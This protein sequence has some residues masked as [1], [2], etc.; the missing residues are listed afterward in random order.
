MESIEIMRMRSPYRGDFV[1]RGFRF[2]G[3][4]RCACIVGGMRGD[5]VQQLFVAGQIVKNLRRME[6]QGRLSAEKG[7]MVIPTV[8]PFSLNVRKRFWAMDNTDVNR[9]FPG[10]SEGETTQRIAAALFE[11]V[12]GYE[13]GVQLAS[14]YMSGSFAPH[15]RV[16]RT[17][18]EDVEGARAFALPYVYLYDPKP[19]D[20]TTLNYNWQVFETKAYSLYSGSTEV[21]DH[22][23]GK[24]TWQA[25]LRFLR[26]VGVCEYHAHP[27]ASPLVF[28]G[29]RL[30][31]VASER[32]GM[33]YRRVAVGESVR[34]GDVLAR[35]LDPFTGETLQTLT[36]P[37]DGAVFFAHT[38]ALAHQH[39]RLFQIVEY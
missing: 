30:R 36:S 29:S 37:A 27:G 1:V 25:A 39:T 2:G 16:M 18:Y 15:V 35:V 26:S 4:E 10:Y 32:G 3:A 20:T 17:G 38:H 21:L 9:M 28:D 11:A 33:L 8:N 31:T 13:W 14:Y 22:G 12:R 34:Q 6:E 19:F 23:L 7:V 24:P 5:E